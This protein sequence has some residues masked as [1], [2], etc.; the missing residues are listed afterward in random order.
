MERYVGDLKVDDERLISLDPENLYRFALA[1]YPYMMT[2]DQV[3]EFTGISAQEIRKLL[4][5][6]E[7]KGSRI[8][9]K[10]LVPK[11]SLLMYLN[12]DRQAV[13]EGG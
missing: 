13:Q 9:S 6:G 11:A 5:R 7:L 2:P 3:S 12:K 1:S 10:W 4:N 8:G